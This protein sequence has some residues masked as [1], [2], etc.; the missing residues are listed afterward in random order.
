VSIGACLESG[1]A[2]RARFGVA[3]TWVEDELYGDA[4]VGVSPF[5]NYRRRALKSQRTLVKHITVFAPSPF[6]GPRPR[7]RV[8]QGRQRQTLRRPVLIFFLIFFSWKFLL[9]SYNSCKRL[10]LLLLSFSS[11]LLSSFCLHSLLNRSWCKLE[12]N[13][14]LIYLFFRIELD[15][16]ST[17]VVN[18]ISPPPPLIPLS[19]FCLCSLLNRFWRNWKLNKFV[20][21]LELSHPTHDLLIICNFY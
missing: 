15:F 11:P 18:W 3:Q 8:E 4:C 1:K 12:Y 16:I 20:T 17:F 13:L 19:S 14:A 21:L 10:V 7:Y 5:Y 6:K 2:W 9:W